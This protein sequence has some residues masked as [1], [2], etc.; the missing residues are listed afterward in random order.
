MMPWKL[1]KDI[2]PHNKQ[3]ALMAAVL[4]FLK[5]LEQDMGS[6]IDCHVIPW[7]SKIKKIFRFK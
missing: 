2:C 4:R 6:I 5:V 7:E 3:G 1:L